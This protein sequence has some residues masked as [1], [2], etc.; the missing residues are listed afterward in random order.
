LLAE[1]TFIIDENGT[2]AELVFGPR[3]G[4]LPEPIALDVLPMDEST[5]T[6]AEQ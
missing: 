5:Q 6:P 1:V 3:Q 4:F 2:H